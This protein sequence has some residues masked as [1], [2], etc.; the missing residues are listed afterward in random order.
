MDLECPAKKRSVV[1]LQTS[2]IHEL[3]SRALPVVQTASGRAVLET[4]SP[5]LADPRVIFSW[6]VK[7]LQDFYTS[8]ICMYVVY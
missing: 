3:A 2:P 4:E 7:I 8:L 1:M 6:E 5:F